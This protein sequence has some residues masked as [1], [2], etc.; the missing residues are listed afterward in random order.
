MCAMIRVNIEPDSI[1]DALQ[2][3]KEGNDYLLWKVHDAEAIVAE[4]K[5][6]LSDV[7]PAA[8][9]PVARVVAFLAVEE[10][11]NQIEESIE[12]ICNNI[13]N[14]F[15]SPDDFEKADEEDE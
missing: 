11:I 1:D 10:A 2:I 9:T 14:A 15:P 13:E 4:K 5:I 12:Y 6:I 8:D 3:I 7:D